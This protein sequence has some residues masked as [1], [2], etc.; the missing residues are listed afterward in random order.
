LENAIAHMR[1]TLV[2]PQRARET[3][4]EPARRQ[5]YQKRE[6][7]VKAGTVRRADRAPTLSQTERVGAPAKE[8]AKATASATPNTERGGSCEIRV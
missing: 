5:R 8:E 2:E 1:A 6:Q 7:I 3:A 4:K